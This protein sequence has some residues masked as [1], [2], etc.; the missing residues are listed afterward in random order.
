MGERILVVGSVALDSVK[1]PAGEALENLGGSAVYFSLSASLFAPV[2]VVGVVGEDFPARH[3]ELLERRGVDLKGLKTLPGLTFR[4]EGR[5]GE[6]F[7]NA[8]T[9]ATHLNV[10]EHFKPALEEAQK[11][12]PYL[13]L[14]NIDPELQFEVLSQMRRPRL[15]ACDTMNYWIDLKRP[16]L[17]EL[18]SRVDVLFV[19]EE[20]A[21]R[22]SGRTRVTEAAALLQSWGP[23]AVVVKKG[24]NGV[25]LL[26][27]GAV[28][29]LPAFPVPAVFDPTG[30]GD[31]FAGG[32]MGYLASRGGALGDL[33]ALRCATLVGSA[34]AS[35]G[36]EAFGTRRFEE[37]TLADLKRR[38]ESFTRQLAV[39]PLFDG[40]LTL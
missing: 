3:R 5:Y 31:S 21:R 15:T 19:N 6:D 11:E 39:R 37:I 29:Q 25:H 35:F 14:A 34:L 10:F 13:F 24:E 1:T 27:Q 26:A 7:A 38:C 4:W 22:L 40:A 8:Q 18:L 12:A 9:I 28:F 16:A 23:A 32:F 17:K 20:E 33:E 2:S 30:A 36:V